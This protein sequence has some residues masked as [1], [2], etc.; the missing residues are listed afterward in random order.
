MKFQKIIVKNKGKMSSFV[1]IIA[2][3]IKRSRGEVKG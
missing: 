1:E 3:S 2:S